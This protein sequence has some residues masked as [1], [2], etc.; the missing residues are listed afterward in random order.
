MI[1]VGLAE[2]VT[3]DD[4]RNDAAV[5]DGEDRQLIARIASERSRD[6]FE[7]LYRRYRQR[8][9]AFVGRIVRNADVC[10]EVYN[11]VMLSVWR[12]CGDFNGRSRVSTWIFAI[13]YRQCLKALKRIPNTVELQDYDVPEPGMAGALINQQLIERAKDHLSSE[14]RLV[15]ELFYFNG[16]TLK[17]IAEITGDPEN[18]VKTR[19]FYARKK[20][21]SLVDTLGGGTEEASDD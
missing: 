4:T 18:P 17:E 21:K 3:V 10:D 5:S 11:D 20:L 14:H 13:A 1:S 19:M 7:E 8:V 9:G 16:S 6:A 15:I 2:Q 12:K